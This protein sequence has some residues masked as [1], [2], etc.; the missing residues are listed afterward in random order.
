MIGAIGAILFGA[1]FAGSWIV[2]EDR[3]QSVR[4]NGGKYY[5]DKNRN[6]R[7]SDTGKKYTTEDALNAIYRE[8]QIRENK[9]EKRRKKYWG[10]LKFEVA[11]VGKNGK[12]YMILDYGTITHVNP[13]VELFDNYKDCLEA[14]NKQKEIYRKL[15]VDEHNIFIKMKCEEFSEDDILSHK[16][17]DKREIHYNF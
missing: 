9:E 15:G 1:V 8:R 14:Y 5:F 4:K 6:L 12:S 16:K 7:Y 2:A 13:T 10:F 11:D 17:I 3:E